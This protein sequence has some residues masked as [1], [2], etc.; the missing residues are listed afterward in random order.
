MSNVI[1]YYLQHINGLILVLLHFTFVV[2]LIWV[3]VSCY[4]FTLSAR[5]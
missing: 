5:I 2:F 1:P 4:I 3:L